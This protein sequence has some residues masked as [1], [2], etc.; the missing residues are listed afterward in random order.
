M[1]PY[2]SIFDSSFVFANESN[3]VI[4]ENNA[5]DVIDCGRI[6][7]ERELSDEYMSITL[8]EVVECAK[9]VSLEQNY[10]VS[11][12]GTCNEADLMVY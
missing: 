6:F 12:V 2:E 10:V 7:N 1:L 5:N 8:D 3:S 4:A 11:A 9:R